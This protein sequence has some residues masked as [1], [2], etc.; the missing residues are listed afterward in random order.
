MF[1]IRIYVGKQKPSSF[2]EFL[3]P[4]CTEINLIRDL[5]GVLINGNTKRLM[6]RA[7]ICDSPARS[8]VTG[9]QYS[10]HP[11][12]CP[13]CVQVSTHEVYNSTVGVLRT[14][15]SFY[16]RLDKT[17]HTAKYEATHSVLENTRFRM[18]TQFPLD[19]MHQVDLGVCKQ[20]LVLIK[21]RKN[22]EQMSVTE[23]EAMD[24][25]FISYN[26]FT[27]RKFARHPR[28]LK[29][30]PFFKATEFRQFLLYSGLVLFKSYMTELAYQH[31]HLL[32]CSYRVLC[33][34][35][36]VGNLSEVNEWLSLF[37]RNYKTFYYK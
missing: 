33:S 19:V 4:F 20:I 16:Y 15:G 8:E 5:G 3:T 21:T 35:N 22:R 24:T 2:D 23:I 12:G 34:S 1:P 11:N 6:I 27:P 17:H 26:R 32:V 30:L 36:F 31:Y 25:Q 29:E 37:V 7:F 28:S 13:K 10:G 9:T 14:D 18:V